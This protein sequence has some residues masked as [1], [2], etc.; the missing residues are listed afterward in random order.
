MMIPEYAEWEEAFRRMMKMV[1]DTR[2]ISATIGEI[3]LMKYPHPETH[4]LEVR[5]YQE[6]WNAAIDRILNME[7]VKTDDNTE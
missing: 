4:K 3:S 5:C 7:E 1:E 2:K 6:G